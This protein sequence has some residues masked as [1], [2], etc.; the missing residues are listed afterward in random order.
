[1]NIDP[2]LVMDM[3]K[4]GKSWNELAAEFRT[5]IYLLRKELT[6]SGKKH[7][8]R[9]TDGGRYATNL[10]SHYQ[11][12]RMKRLKAAGATWKELSKLT[13][14]DPI[15]LERYVNSKRD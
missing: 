15:R 3:R 13:G 14:I 5:S 12:Q 11:L 9:Y 10:L 8:K 2:D 6:A 4:Q 1:M 7:W